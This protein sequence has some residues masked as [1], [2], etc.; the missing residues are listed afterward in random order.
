M[1]YYI[2]SEASIN[3]YLDSRH[4]TLAEPGVRDERVDGAG[5]SRPP[6]CSSSMRL[7]ISEEERHVL[8]SARIPGVE[9]DTGPC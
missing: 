8:F 9:V 7:H 2:R 1:S 3:K 4:R 6:V 5:L